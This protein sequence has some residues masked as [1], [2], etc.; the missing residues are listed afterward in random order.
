MFQKAITESFPLDTRVLSELKSTEVTLPLCSAS[1]ASCFSLEL[2][3]RRLPSQPPDTR[4]LPSGLNFRQ[5][6][7]GFVTSC[8]NG[9]LI[10]PFWS[11][12]RHKLLSTD[13]ETPT[14][15]LVQKSKFVT[16]SE[17]ICLR[18]SILRVAMSHN[19]MVPSS[20]PIRMRD[21]EFELLSSQAAMHIHVPNDFSEASSLRVEIFLLFSRLYTLTCEVSSAAVSKKGDCDPSTYSD[22]QKAR[23]QLL[24]VSGKKANR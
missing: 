6:I 24:K 1:I 7:P 17:W 19:A 20:Y 10:V 21:G 2:N 11:D 12:Q 4:S 15:F 8:L 23:V 9:G 13:P 14:F 18:Q 16:A 22:E 5:A 3:I